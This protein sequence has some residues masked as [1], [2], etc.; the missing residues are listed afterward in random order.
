M[1]ATRTIIHPP[2]LQA[3]KESTRALVR[4]FGGQEAAEELTGRSQSRFSDY[5]NRNT[6]DF[7]PVDLVLALEACTL[8]AAGHPQVTR[9]L[10]RNA[11]FALVRLPQAPAG[12][13]DW[14]QA[15]AAVSRETSESIERV[16][17]ALSDGK[18]TAAEVR[19]LRIREEIAEAHERLAALDALA[20]QA[21]EEG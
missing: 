7:M 1:T 8:G 2:E 5:G 12:D 21:P 17:T 14:H 3:L 4:A 15:I 20:A 18:V 10:A 6:P 19:N 16:C 11:G 13:T 9:L